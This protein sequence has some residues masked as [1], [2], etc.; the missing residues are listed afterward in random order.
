V[1]TSIAST[2]ATPVITLPTHGTSAQPKVSSL[3]LMTSL[4][5]TVAAK[6]TTG[7]PDSLIVRLVVLQ[8]L[9]IVLPLKPVSGNAGEPVLGLTCQRFI[10][11][12]HPTL[13]IIK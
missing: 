1:Q 3:T 9:S 10:L 8:A 7:I 13:D 6:R 4:S 5:S 12:S 2:T 11:K